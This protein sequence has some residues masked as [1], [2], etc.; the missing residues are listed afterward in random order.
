MKKI[1]GLLLFCFIIFGTYA[2]A[3]PPTF[4]PPGIAPDPGET[5][6]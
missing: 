1:S 5:F 2:I 4:G 6:L 3:A